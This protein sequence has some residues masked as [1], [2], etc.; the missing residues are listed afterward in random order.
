MFESASAML[1]DI[2]MRFESH[3]GVVRKFGEMFAK[4]RK[5]E[6][7]YGRTLAQ[8]FDLRQDADYALDA[9]AEI[10]R[11]TAEAELRKAREFVAMAESMLNPSD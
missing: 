7:E 10:S 11:E 8:A 1:A 2:G 6:P 4:T 9:R 5:V 3:Q